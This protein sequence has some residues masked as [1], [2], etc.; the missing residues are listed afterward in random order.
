MKLLKKFKELFEELGG[1]EW[2]KRDEIARQIANLP[3]ATRVYKINCTGDVCK[4]DE[5]LFIKAIWEKIIINR[6]GKKAN[7]IVDFNL[8]EA[9]VIKESYGEKAGQH[10]FT[11]LLK[12]GEKMLIK[13]RNL[14]AFGVWRKERDEEQR[15]KEIEDKH[16]RG[17]IARKERRKKINN[18][19]WR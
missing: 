13:G 3:K 4:N 1:A 10:T 8:T 5:I 6:Y 17:S 9:K 2:H 12:N 16:K 18:F 11:L 14:Y 7:T 15:E 19:M